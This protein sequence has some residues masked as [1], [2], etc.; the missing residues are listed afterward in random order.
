MKGDF[1]VNE[2]CEPFKEI[3]LTNSKKY[4]FLLLIVLALPEKFEELRRA[5]EQSEEGR[6]FYDC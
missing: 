4:W 3:P 1:F 2:E 5:I 6:N